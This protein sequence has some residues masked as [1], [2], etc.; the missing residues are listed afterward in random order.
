MPIIGQE[1]ISLKISTPGLDDPESKYDFTKNVFCVYE[2]G[3]KKSS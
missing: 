1:Y 2:L 3:Y